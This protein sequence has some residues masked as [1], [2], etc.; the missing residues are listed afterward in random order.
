MS[1]ESLP[2]FHVVARLKHEQ[3]VIHLCRDAWICSALMLSMSDDG[4][5]DDAAIQF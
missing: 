2:P 1:Y 5:G 4:D 3:V